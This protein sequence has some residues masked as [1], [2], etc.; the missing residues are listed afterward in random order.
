M[1][2]NLLIPIDVNNPE[3]IKESLDRII[4]ILFSLKDKADLNE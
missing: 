4:Q 1:T 2:A 3:Y